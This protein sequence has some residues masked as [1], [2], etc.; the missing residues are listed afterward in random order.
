MI[1]TCVPLHSRFL[2][3][4]FPK[5]SVTRVVRDI[6]EIQLRKTGVRERE[7]D[8][9]WEMRGRNREDPYLL[10]LLLS[11]FSCVQLCATPSTVSHQAPLCMRFPRQQYWSG[12]PFPSPEDLPNPG[13]ERRFSCISGGLFTDWATREAPHTYYIFGFRRTDCGVYGYFCMC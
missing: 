10:L 12:L 3:T 13:V 8:E 1:I 5:R 7:W 9:R 2:T 4:Y 6:L 11:C